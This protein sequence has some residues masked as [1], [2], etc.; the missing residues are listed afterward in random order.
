M[1]KKEII[2]IIPS[3]EPELSFYEI[4]QEIVLADSGLKLVVVDDGSGTEYEE[5]FNRIMNIPNV[6]ILRHYVNLGKGRALKTAFN[7]VLNEYPDAVGVVTADSDGQ[8]SIEDIIRVKEALLENPFSLILGCRTFDDKCIPLKSRS[9]NVITKAVF[10]YVTGV[11][12]SDTQTGLR[13]IPYNFM[14]CLMNTTGERFEYE[15]NML[16]E[17][18]KKGVSIVEVPIKTL[19]DSKKGHKTHFNPIRDSVKIYAVLL[20]YLLSS[21]SASLVDFIVFSFSTTQGA[22]IVQ[23]TAIARLCACLI[24]FTVN[25]KAVF[26][27]EGSMLIQAIRYLLL[28]CVS[29]AISASM[30]SV[31]SSRV[32]IGIIVLKAIIETLLFF[33]NFYIQRVFV[34]RES[35]S[36]DKATDWTKYYS[37]KK[38]RV[39]SFT[40][41]YTLNELMKY[42]KD[43][44]SVLELGGGNSCFAEDIC[45]KKQLNRYDII[46]NNELSVE[47]FNSI[48]LN[49]ESKGYCINLL[50]KAE[51]DNRYDVV[52]SVGLIEHFRGEAIDTIIGKHFEFCSEGGLVVITFP[53]PTLKYRVCRKMMEL[54]GVWQFWDEKPLRIEDV[55]ESFKK[56]GTVSTYYINRKLPLTQMVV[57]TEKK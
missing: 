47:M 42:F 13:G 26:K 23:A 51:F 29:G 11:K 24:N 25:R 56:R 6:T 37:R 10:H 8:H 4:C 17:S 52:F 12:V 30:I 34:F 1:N 35:E 45:N 53:T 54:L 49:T 57:V 50:E 38:S 9:G 20:T 21:L 55:E 19:Y 43:N 14:A 40:Q 46:D 22:G 33:F 41:K 48:N 5:V 28:V 15:T 18:K 2:V 7:Y 3:Y 27:A 39:S 44:V 31:L 36:E 32:A 16:I